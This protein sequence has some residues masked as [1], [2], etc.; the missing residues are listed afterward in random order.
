MGE[1]LRQGLE[2]YPELFLARCRKGV[3]RPAMERVLHG[4]D[5]MPAF[6]VLVPRISPGELDGRFVRLRAAVAEE[7]L[8][9]ERIF[10]EHLGGLDLRFHVEQ[11]RH[12]EQFL[13]LRGQPLNDLLVCVAK[14]AHGD[15]CKEV[16]VPPPVDIPEPASFALRDCDR[17]PCVGVRD[18]L[19]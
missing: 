16:E 4:D 13:R 5:L 7:D 1:T 3:H 14:V 10:D 19:R 8:V 15:A 2:T 12:V 9:A 6:T 18:I 11:V 17:E